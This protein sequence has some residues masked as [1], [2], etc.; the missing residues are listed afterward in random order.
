VQP[1]LFEGFGLTVLEAMRSGLPVFATM[2]GGPFEIIQEGKS[3][4]HIDPINS[5]ETTNKILDFIKS[6]KKDKIVWERISANAIERVDSAYNWELYA[7]NLL[8][9]AKI[10]GFWKFTTNIEMEEF[11]AY[12]EVLYHLLYKPRANKILELHNNR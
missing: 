12:L 4:F 10:Y 1:A 7:N 6:F 2:Y 11:N 9:L 8:S 3:G 5:I